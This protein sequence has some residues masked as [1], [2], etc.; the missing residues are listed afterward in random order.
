EGPAL[1]GGLGGAAGPAANARP[2][3]VRRRARR[4][5]RPRRSRVRLTVNFLINVQAGE[6][7]GNTPACRRN[8]SLEPL[9]C[10]GKPERIR[11]RMR[12][13]QPGGFATAVQGAWRASRPTR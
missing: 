10:R 4:P 9:T 8:N 11:P 3:P 12:G 5:R 1:R 6:F 13:I 7:L 2:R